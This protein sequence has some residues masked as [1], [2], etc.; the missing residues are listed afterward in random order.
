MRTRNALWIASLLFLG[1]TIRNALHAQ[2]T[3]Q[4]QAIGVRDGGTREVLESIF[5]PPMDKAPFQLT[6]VTEWSRPLGRDGSYTLANHRQIMR[7]NAGRIYQERW[8]LVPKG[9]KVEST[10]NVIQIADPV[11]HVLYN[12]FVAEKQCNLMRYGGST[13]TAYRPDLG[14]SGPLPDGTGFRTHEALGSDSRDGCETRGYRDT[15]TIN[16]GVI[17]NDRPMI[18][19]REFWYC[20]Q[21]GINLSSLLDSPQSG[22]QSF[23]VIELST[24]EPDLQF[25]AAPAG[26]KV[27]DRRNESA[28]EF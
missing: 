7:D 10:M 15:T 14:V 21:L 2:A 5:I 8:L 3:A 24:S 18:T 22:R 28:P 20:P 17:G 6:L 25:F 1:L 27:V 12:C 4:P 9:G 13:T 26:Y 16:P 11:Q 19:T 23:I